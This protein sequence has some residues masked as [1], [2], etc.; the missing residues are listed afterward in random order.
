MTC[1]HLIEA[2]GGEEPNKANGGCSEV[3]VQES[4]SR[5]PAALWVQRSTPQLA[6]CECVGTT[7]R[8]KTKDIYTPKSVRTLTT[9][10]SQTH[11]FHLYL[12]EA[13]LKYSGSCENSVG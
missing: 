11:L 10:S 3:D 7:L 1:C 6:G 13:T 9:L 8:L 4:G 5:F 2:E 12:D